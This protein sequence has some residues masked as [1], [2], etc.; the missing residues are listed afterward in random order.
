MEIS[1][2]GAIVRHIASNPL[3]A[4]DASVLGKQQLILLPKGFK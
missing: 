2:P 1:F 3:L 4:F